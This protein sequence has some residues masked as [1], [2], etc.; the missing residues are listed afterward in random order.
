MQSQRREG[1]ILSGKRPDPIRRIDAAS[2]IRRTSKAIHMSFSH[3]PAISRAELVRRLGCMEQIGGAE[4]FTFAEGPAR[5]MQAV[6]VRTGA[7]LSCQVLTDR[8][9]GLGEASIGG[10][11]VSWLSAAGP[12]APS[13]YNPSGSGWLQSFG[14]GLMTSCGLANVGTASTV[15]GVEIGL[16]GRLSHLPARE[17]AVR[18]HWVDDRFVVDVSGVVR[19]VIAMGTAFELRRNYRFTIGENSFRISDE[20]VNIG[21]AAAPLFL[22]YHFNFGFPLLSETAE[23]DVTP[24]PVSTSVRD[25]TQTADIAT[26]RHMTAPVAGIVERV[27]YHRLAPE[28]GETEVRLSNVVGDTRVIMTMHLPTAELGCLVEWKM[29]G[30]RDYVLGIEPSN[31]FVAGR[32]AILAEGSAEILAPGAL[33]TVD[34]DVGFDLAPAKDA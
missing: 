25:P 23:L 32:D 28:A 9:M 24:P 22:L 26:W 1:E 20:I 5:G 16:H 12:V 34:I 30:E 14:G 27:F 15:D 2:P 6:C 8:G 11:P 29:M 17:V 18:R 10:I 21:A 3:F 31:C 33:K 4:V 7:G 13:Y 19:D